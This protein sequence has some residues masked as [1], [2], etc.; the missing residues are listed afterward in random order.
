MYTSAQ[1]KAAA[2]SAC[3][4]A[5]SSAEF[6][7]SPTTRMPRPPTS[8][9]SLQHHGI[10]NLFGRSSASSADCQYPCEPGRIGTPVLFMTALAR[11]FRPIVRITSGLGTDELDSRCLADFGEIGVLA[12]E[13]VTGMYR[14]DVRDFRRADYRRNVEIASRA[15]CRSDA[16]RFVGEAHVEAVAVGFRIN[17]DRLNTEVLA[18]ADHAERDLAAVGDQYFL[19]MSDAASRTDGEQSFAVFHGAAVLHQLC[20]EVPATSDSI[21]FISFIDS[22]MQSTFPV[23]TW[24]AQLQTKRGAP[25]EGAS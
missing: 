23:S 14:V 5:S 18:R 19:N 16:D 2:A 8:R 15:L 17:R 21:S 1:E 10:A 20:D 13:A 4:W 9:R 24:F 7:R 11:C 12:Q 6:G 3:A 22:M 25:G